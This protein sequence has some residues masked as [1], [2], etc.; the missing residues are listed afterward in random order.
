MV[1]ENLGIKID[2]SEK[3]TLNFESSVKALN[4]SEMRKSSKKLG[5]MGPFVK[6]RCWDVTS[7]CI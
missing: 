4:T 6:L 3:N 1:K 5:F 7:L 2:Y